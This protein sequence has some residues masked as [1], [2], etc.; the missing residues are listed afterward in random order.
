VTVTPV[1]M[2][3]LVVAMAVVNIAFR[4]GPIAMLSR[5]RLPLPV[6]RW[7]SFV[8]AS[9]MSAL[10]ATEILRPGGHWLLPWQNVYLFAAVPTAL[11]Y[12]KT[13]SF[14]G[15]SVTGMVAFLALRYF[16]G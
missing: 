12:W 8:P 3:S 1:M 13:K 5:L 2:W 16:L 7:L 6:E 4:W 10:V 14:L 9:V 15:A 11:V